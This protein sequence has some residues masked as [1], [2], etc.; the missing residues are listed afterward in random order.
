MVSLI[1]F[2]VGIFLI[3]I[4]LKFSEKDNSCYNQQWYKDAKNKFGEDYYYPPSTHTTCMNS[5]GLHIRT[6]QHYKP[7]R[8]SIYSPAFDKLIPW[9]VEIKICY[10]GGCEK[11]VNR[12]F[13]KVK[14]E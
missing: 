5:E 4:L 13:G 1:S 12:Y 9:F 11:V 3:I 14:N 8:H 6:S 7:V 2:I 10:D